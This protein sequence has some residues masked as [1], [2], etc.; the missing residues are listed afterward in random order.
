MWPFNRYKKKDSVSSLW[1]VLEGS[2]FYLLQKHM[3]VSVQCSTLLD[4]F[5][6]AACEGD[7]KQAHGYQQEAVKLELAADRLKNKLKLHMHKGLLLPVARSDLLSILTAQDN[8]ANTTKDIIGIVYGRKMVFPVEVRTHI[9]NFYRKSILACN[10][11]R[12]IVDE[13]DDLFQSGFSS[14][15]IESTEAMIG[16]LDEIE[17]Q[18]DVLQIEVRKALF[19]HESVMPPVDVVFLYQVIQDIG[20]LADWAQR[21]GAKLLLLLAR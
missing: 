7:W 8:I 4:P 13:I 6:L 21:V 3:R 1:G 15:M 5:M 17:E 2:P 16:L 12:E 11:A 10:K 14:R 9:I 18:T 20:H 19:D